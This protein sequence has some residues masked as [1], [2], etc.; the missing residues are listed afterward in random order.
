[1]NIGTETFDEEKKVD[2]LTIGANGFVMKYPRPKCVRKSTNEEN[3]EN[4]EKGKESKR[5]NPQHM[6]SGREFAD[7]LEACRPRNR[8]D[9]VKMMPSAL[10]SLLRQ[11]SVSGQANNTTTYFS[12]GQKE[13]E[14]K[15]SS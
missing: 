3:S 7:I 4:A 2:C 13:S 9:S 6:I 12:K 10:K 14:E 11:N 8:G 1:M 15:E 5:V